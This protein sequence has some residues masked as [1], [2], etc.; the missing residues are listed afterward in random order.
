MPAVISRFNTPYKSICLLAVALSLSIQAQGLD[1]GYIEV[2]GTQ[3]QIKAAGMIKL[4]LI[5]DSGEMANKVGFSPATIDTSDD[6]HEIETN[7]SALTSKLGILSKTDLD[8]GKSLTTRIEFDF[9]GY[10]GN[11]GQPDGGVDIQILHLVANYENW[12][13][14]QTYSSFMDISTFP[15]SLDYWGPNSLVFL[16]IPQVT[17][18]LGLGDNSHIAL[19]LEDPTAT[20][21]SSAIIGATDSHRLPNFAGHWRLESGISHIQV[22]G[23][24]REIGYETAK[25]AEYAYGLGMNVSGRIDIGSSMALVGQ[26]ATGFG[27]N[28][29]INDG[30]AGSQDAVI[31]ANGDLELVASTGLMGFFEIAYLEKFTSTAGFGYFT[32]DTDDLAASSIDHTT[33]LLG[34]IIYSVAAP[35][36]VGAEI[37]FGER[38]DKNG[39]S[40]NNIR[41]QVSGTFRF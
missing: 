40:G 16:S 22:A 11:M 9:V 12:Q 24:V 2:P 30:N 37:M 39:D 28:R 13:V 5:T 23:M 4:D 27:I 25:D 26:A 33:Y 14:G 32:Q 38:E 34:N 41:L 10:G 8:N 18:T 7:F 3:T 36:S 6:N 31:K 17:Y 15:N 21:T 1:H 35:L 19:G 29:F 20:G